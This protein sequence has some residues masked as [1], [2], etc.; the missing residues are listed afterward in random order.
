[1]NVLLD[2]KIFV[3]AVLAFPLASNSC[4]CGS[5]KALIRPPKGEEVSPG[6]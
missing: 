1:M 4:P 2:S 6:F 5:R 3:L